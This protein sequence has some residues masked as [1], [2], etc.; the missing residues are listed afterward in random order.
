MLVECDHASLSACSY[1]VMTFVVSKPPTDSTILYT[2]PDVPS[3]RSSARSAS[4]ARRYRE[5]CP[6]VKETLLQT[7]LLEA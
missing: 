7:N 3:R 5:R 2:A 4:A 6:L 1:V